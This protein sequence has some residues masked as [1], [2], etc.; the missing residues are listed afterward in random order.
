MLSEKK[1]KIVLR[2]L[3]QSNVVTD[4]GLLLETL[5]TGSRMSVFRRLKKMKYIS[6]YTH[7]GRYYTLSTT[8]QF[9]QNGLWFYQGI[10]YSRFGTLKNT[11]IALT[12]RSEEG[13]TLAELQKMLRVRVQDTLLGLYNSKS[14]HREKVGGSYVYLCSNKSE[15]KLQ[16]HRRSTSIKINASLTV[17]VKLEVLVEAIKE[18]KIELSADSITAKLNAN[19]INIASA[20]VRNL[21]KSYGIKVK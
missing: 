8:P 11:I 14:I 17:T 20:Q 1:S 5:E 16:L 19:D 18:C 10:G 21:L 2:N 15:A 3:F 7:A 6:S 13:M 9:N 12:K 4:M